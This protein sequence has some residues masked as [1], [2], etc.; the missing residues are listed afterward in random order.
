M[1][2]VEELAEA[3]AAASRYADILGEGRVKLLDSNRRVMG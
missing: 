2:E 3:I 1:C